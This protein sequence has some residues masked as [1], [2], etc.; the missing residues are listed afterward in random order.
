ML[1]TM[2]VIW[3][4]KANG[5]HYEEME[6]LT[7]PPEQIFIIEVLIGTLGGIMD[8][9]ITISSAIKELYDK[10]PDMGIKRMIQ[11][12]MEI[13]KDIMGTMA[14]T[15][16]FAYISGSIP[17][18]LLWLKNGIPIFNIINININLELIRAFTGSIGIVLSIPIT[19]YISVLLLRN[20][21]IGE[22]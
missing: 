9:A 3:I 17:M 7:R 20:N 15:L 18:I 14:N 1:I 2:V 12:G 6:F 19:L 16:V 11:S 4:T 8:I 22:A 10:N 5:I 13:G 21:K